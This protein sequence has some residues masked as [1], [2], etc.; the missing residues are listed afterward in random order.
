M[1]KIKIT[2][3][4]LAVLMVVTAFAGC[5]SKSTVA[6]LDEKVNDLDGKIKDQSEAL[7]GITSTLADIQKALN[8]QTPS[9]DLDSIKKDVEENNKEI[10]KILEEL[11]KQLEDVKKQ[12]DAATGNDDAVKKAISQTG[13]KIDDLKGKFEDAK[14]NYTA[15]DIAAIRQ[16]FGDVQATISACTTVDAVN[17]AFAD[18]QKKLA[19]HKAVN[20]KL[21]DYVL[22]LKGNITDAS[23]D[24][25]A[26]AV[27]ALAG[28][29]KFY[30]DDATVK[31]LVEYPI[32][33]DETINL[34]DAINDL[35]TAQNSELPAVKAAAAELVKKIDE[36]DAT[37]SFN[38]VTEILTEYKKWER[39][40]NKLSPENV[41]LVT[42]YDKLVKAQA[43]AL[44]A[45]TA[46][47]MF[48]AETI[49]S[50]LSDREVG[51][52]GDYDSLLADNI[53][54]VFTYT[55]KDGKL[56]LTSEIYAAIDAKISAWAKEYELTD[57]AVEYIIDTVAKQAGKGDNYYAKYKA[58]KALVAAFE[59]E[60]TKLVATN[61]IFSAIKALNSKKLGTDA[62]EIANA[63][64]KNAS[65]INAWKDA[66][67]K[68]YENELKADEDPLSNRTIFSIEKYNAALTANFNAM[69]VKAQLCVYD[70]TTKTYAEYGLGFL[71]D[72]K[73]D[74]NEN[75][76]YFRLYD[77]GDAKLADFIRVTFP[78]AQD[79]ADAINKKIANFNASQALSIKDIMVGIGGYVKFDGV[80]KLLANTTDDI[81]ATLA[82]NSNTPKTIAEFIYVYK[83]TA[84]Y[85]L[86]GMINVADY[87][88]K[89]AAVE[90][91]IKNADAAAAAL[92]DA[93]GALVGENGVAIT[94]ANAA[95]AKDVYSLFTKWLNV[96]NK[97]MQ[98]ATLINTTAAGIKEYK[99]NDILVNYE[100]I[101]AE[102]VRDTNSG[103]I[104]TLK[105]KADAIL[106]EETL[107]ESI[108]Q[109]MDKVNAF[110]N[111]A[112]GYDNN[113]NNGVVKATY[114]GS[115]N[116][117]NTQGV[118]SVTISE[119]PMTADGRDASGK[120]YKKDMYLW[121]VKYVAY[122]GTKFV[123]STYSNYYYTNDKAK[124]GAAIGV[125]GTSLGDY[126]KGQLWAPTGLDYTNAFANGLREV[127]PNKIKAQ[128]IDYVTKNKLIPSYVM[129]IV[130]MNLEAKFIVDNLGTTSKVEA[131]K[132]NWDPENGGYGFNYIK[133]VTKAI[134]VADGVAYANPETDAYK[135]ATSMDALRLV[136][137]ND[138]L[139]YEEASSTKYNKSIVYGKADYSW[140]TPL[141]NDV[142]F[143]ALGY[144]TADFKAD[145]IVIYFVCDHTALAA[146]SCDPETTCPECG[147]VVAGTKAHTFEHAC[148]KTCAECG[149]ANTNRVHTAPAGVTCGNATEYECT[150][151]HETVA[152]THDFA[153]TAVW[154]VDVS[155]E[156]K[157]VATVT[158]TC[159]VCGANQEAKGF[160]VAVVDVDESGDLSNGDTVS[161]TMILPDGTK[162]I[163]KGVYTDGAFTAEVIPQA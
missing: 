10:Q 86:S 64:K 25:V 42:N 24:K 82:A 91:I 85:D 44:N 157:Y 58:N 108:Y 137:N 34:V 153:Y 46:K 59:A 19:E 20:E 113:Q 4:V 52:F 148:D 70:K 43:S 93:Y 125:D 156:T 95:K 73:D 142:D 120:Q 3:L 84:V 74:S 30:D 146:N 90:K 149:A 63:Y 88:A 14:S 145:G 151:C 152:I 158:L 7:A 154:T 138:I 53:Q 80:N 23:A 28:A 35:N 17:A 57:A 22:A 143:A 40:A 9:T 102:S 78:K 79:A 134:L 106:K 115:H 67:V 131:A 45:D 48:G 39:R 119:S 13:A 32:G 55:N 124:I 133:A 33:E 65:D 94:T 114:A 160:G 112:F 76:Y 71:A 99:L 109:M 36:I 29:I 105:K 18:M 132:K 161:T 123:E 121:T 150:V 135:L 107:V 60:Y 11:K 77:L 103:E 89:V 116:N 144:D 117:F 159:S 111:Q 41:K 96:G 98:T 92:N 51:I 101:V 5:A 162:V 38:R 21:Y 69:V 16:I 104:V 47:T 49:S 68:A 127:V 129:P 56:A 136:V 54:V 62:V 81:K 147:A 87:E 26:E 2:A 15:E 155:D 130:A 1:R 6:N 83:T 128:G 97:Q 50:K 72:L 139:R 75:A 110:S 163:V 12:A 100:N 122:N 8:N 140:M 37:Y 31:A 61:G 126:I 27:D 66:L 141:F 118:T